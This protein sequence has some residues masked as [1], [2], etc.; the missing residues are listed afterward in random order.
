MFKPISV[1]AEFVRQTTPPMPADAV[2]NVF[3][4]MHGFY[5]NLFL[6][7]YATSETDANGQDSG[8]VSARQIWAHGLRRFNAS[9]VR[10]ALS[11]PEML[12]A[13][14]HDVPR[15]FMGVFAGGCGLA[16]LAGVIGGST[17]LTEPAM[18]AT[19]K[20]VNGRKSGLSLIAMP[21]RQAIA[22]SRPQPAAATPRSMDWASGRLP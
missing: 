7:K 21:I 6:S 3:K 5:G 1:T 12:R 22:K 2:N 13:L 8:V 19:V 11:Q 20:I 10:A 18:A 14:G 17:F 9:T 4:V 16:G 15:V